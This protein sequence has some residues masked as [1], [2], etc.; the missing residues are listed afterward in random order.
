MY[1]NNDLNSLFG[2][3]EKGKIII[4]DIDLEL[5][6]IQVV[7]IYISYLNKSYKILT[8]QGYFSK[9]P[10]ISEGYMIDGNY[11]LKIIDNKLTLFLYNTNLANLS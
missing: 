6:E 11:I 7:H 2:I 3:F 8:T 10:S 4:F 9:I 1:S 5:I